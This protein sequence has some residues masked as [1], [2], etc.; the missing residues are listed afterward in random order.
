VL[1]NV[2]SALGDVRRKAT[3]VPCVTLALN[4]GARLIV[5]FVAAGTATAS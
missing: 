2:I 5:V 1:G 3:H 4:F